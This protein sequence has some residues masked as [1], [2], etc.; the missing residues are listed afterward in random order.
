MDYAQWKLSD[1]RDELVRQ[2]AIHEAAAKERR[3]IAVE[4]RRRERDAAIKAKLTTM[5]AA[6]KEA[7]RAVLEKP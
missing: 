3:A 6:E 5:T 2:A 4:I 1:L 7:L